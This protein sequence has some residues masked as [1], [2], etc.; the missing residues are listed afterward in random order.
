[1]LQVVAN[2]ELNENNGNEILPA[3][4]GLRAPIRVFN[5]FD[6]LMCF[7]ISNLRDFDQFERENIVFVSNFT[8]SLA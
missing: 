3:N 5:G 7:V 4:S 6:R 2:I 1:L 8:K